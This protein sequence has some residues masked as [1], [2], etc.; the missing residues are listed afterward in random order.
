MVVAAVYIFIVNL[1]DTTVK[2]PEIIE[3]EFNLPVLTSIPILRR[4]NGKKNNKKGGN[5]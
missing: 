3:K 4:E 2:T 5:K 1:L